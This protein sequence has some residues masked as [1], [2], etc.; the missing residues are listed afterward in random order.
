MYCGLDL[1]CPV[2]SGTLFKGLMRVNAKN[3]RQA[4]ITVHHHELDAPASVDAPNGGDDIKSSV[5]A[6]PAKL[7]QHQDGAG[8]DIDIYIDGQVDR[9][10]AYEG[11]I[12]AVQLLPPDQWR[13]VESKEAL[14]K[15]EHA[16]QRRKRASER[17]DPDDSDADS[18]SDD[19]EPDPSIRI[20]PFNP[21]TSDATA[22]AGSDAPN[23]PLMQ[24]VGRVVAILKANRALDAVNGY[25]QLG[26]PY[27]LCTAA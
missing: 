1:S 15:R 14:K 16:D 22:A 6:A 8:N 19:A 12:V 26:K 11:D 9:N 10:R 21:L 23:G 7:Y 3:P 4:Y 20:D 13:T 25:L 24:P 27:V 17:V 2:Q 18:A 5:A